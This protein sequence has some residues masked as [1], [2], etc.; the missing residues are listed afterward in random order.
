MITKLTALNTIAEK[1]GYESWLVLKFEVDPYR[2]N[3][4]IYEAM[5]LYAEGRQNKPNCGHVW[6]Y[7]KDDTVRCINC[8]KS[9]Y[10]N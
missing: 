7:G 1:Y 2:I 10:D 9:L 8:N 4:M 3:E 5:D 6:G